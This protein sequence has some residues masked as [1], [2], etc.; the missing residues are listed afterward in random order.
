MFKISR[1]NRFAYS[2]TFVLYTAPLAVAFSLIWLGF[3]GLLIQGISKPDGGHVVVG[4]FGT[5]AVLPLVLV[6][7]RNYRESLRDYRASRKQQKRH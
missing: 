3:V 4:L 1:R 5:L 7:I 6:S 2:K